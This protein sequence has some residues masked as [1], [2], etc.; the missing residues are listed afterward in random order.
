MYDINALFRSYCIAIVLLLS[1]NSAHADSLLESWGISAFLGISPSTQ[2]FVTRVAQ[3]EMFQ[4]EMAKLADERGSERTKRFV[5][6]MLSEHKEASTQLKR[7]VSGGAAQVAYP[8]TLNR[9]D[10]DKVDA[11]KKLSGAEFE[12]EFDEAQI[13]L[14][15]DMVSLFER[16]GSG[17]SH[18]DLKQFAYR[19]L[20]HIREHWR[21]VREQK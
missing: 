2:D 17:G 11:L 4:A 12:S 8:T 19:H 15:R 9:A 20:P 5:A 18:P 16:Y 21:I 3:A 1:S 10:Q 13:T 6:R 14:H 7:L